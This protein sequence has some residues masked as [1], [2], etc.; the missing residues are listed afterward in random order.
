VSL[1]FS[2]QLSRCARSVATLVGL[3][4]LVAACGGD[5]DDEIIEGERVPVLVYDTGLRV[6]DS[7]KDREVRLPQPYAN[8]AWPQ[9]GGY[10]DHAMHHLAAGEQL[11]IAW[12]ASI[13]AGSRSRTDLL[14]RLLLSQRRRL[15]T[16][17]VI[18]LGT[19]Y[20]M[21]AETVVTAFDESEG[22]RKWRTDLKPKD[23]EE[24][25]GIFG[26]GLALAEGALFAT[27]G[28]GTVIAVDPNSGETIWTANIGKPIRG[29]PTVG[30]G[31]VYAISFDNQLYALSATTGEVLWVHEGFLENAGLLGAGSP[32]VAGGL[33]VVP[34]SSGELYALRVDNGR[35][36]WSDTLMRT[37]L[38][39]PM[40]AL[41]D[42]DA[43]PI[44]DGNKVYSVSNGGR[45]AAIELRSGDRIWERNIAAHE[46]PWLAGD[47]LYLVTESSEVVCL[48]KIDGKI[49]WVTKLPRYNN[50]AEREDPLRWS[51]P[52]LVSDRLIVTSSHGYAASLSPYTGKF[53]GRSELV[54]AVV[55]PPV[56]AN[57]GLYFLTEDGELV[58]MR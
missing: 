10:P 51:G 6:D 29:A 14:N 2:H 16:S 17:P 49:H 7:V 22:E 27:T 4:L 31:Q 15:L 54:G 20:T 30:G 12:R 25:G 19:V 38:M 32:A 28:Y 33:V 1:H 46:S 36:A 55:I 52:V 34:F 40:A 47:Y 18:A 57:S 53:L 44:V 45:M 3:S 11:E 39:T 43:R 5:N 48:S 37:G 24:H 9:A 58:V 56:V 42:I 41:S 23:G 21:D 13:G 50:D 8:E 26:G 35:V